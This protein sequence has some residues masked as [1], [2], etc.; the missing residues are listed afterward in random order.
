MIN[1]DNV[2]YSATRSLAECR[3][4]SFIMQSVNEEGRH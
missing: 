4:L 1:E 3:F 2:L